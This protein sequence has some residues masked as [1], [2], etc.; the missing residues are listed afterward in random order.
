M[1]VS[2][3]VTNHTLEGLQSGR[4]C[5]FRVYARD[6]AGN[7]SKSSNPVTVTVPGELA[8]PTKPVVELLDVG[9]THASLSW[10]ST[11]DG[12]Y[13]WYTIYIDGQPVSTLN[14]TT[15][16]FTCASVFVP[17]YCDPLN[18]ETTYAFTVRARDVDGTCRRSATPSS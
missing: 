18:Q 11:D 4:T 7:L 1:I 3:T 14:S 5:I 8:A 2:Q 17:T 15:G 13:I 12:P 9:P 10:L 16:T 6:A